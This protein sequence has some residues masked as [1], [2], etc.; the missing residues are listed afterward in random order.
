MYQYGYYEL[1]GNKF[2]KPPILQS[3]LIFAQKSLREWNM[4]VSEWQSHEQ[5]VLWISL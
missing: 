5:Q 4:W 2:T 1:L 3:V